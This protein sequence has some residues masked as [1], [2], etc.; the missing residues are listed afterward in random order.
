MRILVVFLFLVAFLLSCD[1][2]E[3][4]SYGL[5]YNT[6]SSSSV[7]EEKVEIVYGRYL[8]CGACCS[9]VSYPASPY[10]YTF[11]DP[12]EDATE[13]EKR[14]FPKDFTVQLG[15]GAIVSFDYQVEF[16]IMNEEDAKKV[17]FSIRSNEKE[18]ETY[19]RGNMRSLILEKANRLAKSYT[20][21]SEY[22]DS[23][24][25]FNDK[26]F[27]ELSTVFL[28]DG[29]TLKRGFIVGVVQFDKAIQDQINALAKAKG[30]I[31]QAEA[32][33][34][35][36]TANAQKDIQRAKADSTEQVIR[37]L[38]AAKSKIIA[39]Q[40]EAEANELLRKSLSPE[41]IAFEKAKRYQQTIT[42]MMPNGQ[43]VDITKLQENWDKNK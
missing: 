39:A 7:K 19:L 30:D 33:A 15:S 41:L 9:I 10:I 13:A 20:S 11:N 2:V 31:A 4:M 27:A 36:V 43:V 1:G 3:R 34:R 24:T 37:A 25:V 12:A 28:E 32:D 35:I 18:F 29:I 42:L 16:Q 23:I 22:N 26:L 40:A 17:F 21:P 5:R 6:C 14:A 38:S 8:S